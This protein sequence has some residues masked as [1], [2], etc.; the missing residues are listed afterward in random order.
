MGPSMCALW[1]VWSPWE[2]WGIWLVDTVVL[3]MGL[4]T[5]SAASVLSLTPPLETPCSV[6]WLAVNICLCTLQD[7]AE[8]LRRQQY[9]TPES[10]HFLA[11]TTLSGFS[12]CIWDGSPGGAVS[13]WPFFSLCPTLYPYIS[14][15]VYFVPPSKK[16]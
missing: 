12:N 5:S 8:P 13:G 14:S 4:Q 7:L 2:L 16:D 9:L 3:P 15:C 1:L 10:M 6:Q 11:S